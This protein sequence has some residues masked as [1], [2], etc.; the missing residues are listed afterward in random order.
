MAVLG[1]NGSG[2]S[3]FI[4]LLG[5]D[6][7]VGFKGDWKLGARV[8][9]GLFAQTHAH[10]EFIGKELVEILWLERSLQRGPAVSVLRRYE[11]EHQVDQEFQTL[12]G[13]PA[14]PPSDPP[15]RVGRSHLAAAR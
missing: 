13:G 10:P 6:P 1:A 4:R 2:K 11:L 7:T 9:T 14:S 5:G 3:H 15:P 12:S 8:V